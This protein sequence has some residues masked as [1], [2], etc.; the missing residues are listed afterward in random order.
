MWR[1]FRYF[2]LILWNTGNRNVFKKFTFNLKCF[3][4]GFWFTFNSITQNVKVNEIK[5]IRIDKK[6]FRPNEVDYLKGDARKAYKKLRFKPKYTFL[7]L[8]KD[9]INNDLELAKKELL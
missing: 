2:S 5:I 3:S 1:C 7:Q 6:Y 4:D 9:M 8:V